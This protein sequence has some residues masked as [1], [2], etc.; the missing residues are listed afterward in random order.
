[1]RSTV[2]PEVV[3]LHV[4]SVCNLHCTYCFGQFPG[5]S[6]PP[7]KVDWRRI[8]EALAVSRVQRVNFSGGEP[9]LFPELVPLLKHARGLGLSTSIVTNGKKLTDEV[10]SLCD[11]VALSIDSDSEAVNAQLGRLTRGERSSY[12]RVMR[13][14]AARVRKAQKVLKVNTVVT[15][16]NVHQDLKSL[17]RSL[18]PEKVKLL[19]FRRVVGENEDRAAELEV[20][21]RDFDAFVERHA[22]LRRENIWVQEESEATIGTTYVMVNPEGRLFQHA[23]D[24]THVLSRPLAEVGLEEAM[25]DVGGYDRDKFEMRG[26]HVDVRSL[27]GGAR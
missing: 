9:T 11:A 4:T 27:A 10:I 1:M 19:Q 25:R 22:A 24:N 17:Y 18:Q 7:P 3:N 16:I 15:S 12:L 13:L 20:S 26:G 14:L 5:V 2:T 6:R 8:L 23:A 21:R